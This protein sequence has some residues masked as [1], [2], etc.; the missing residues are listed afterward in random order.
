MSASAQAV[1]KRCSRRDQVPAVAGAGGGEQLAEQF[2]AAPGGADLVGRVVAGQ[3]PLQ[4]GQRPR[5]QGVA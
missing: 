5:G 2:L 1:R 3:H 4:P